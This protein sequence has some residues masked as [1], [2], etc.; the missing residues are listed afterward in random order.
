MAQGLVSPLA[1]TAGRNFYNTTGNT[2]IT[3]N[4]VFTSTV[5]TYNSNALMANLLPALTN[6]AALVSAS[7]MSTA[8][9]NSIRT[10]GNST[11]PALA[12]SVPV[13]ISVTIGNTGVTGQMLANAS[14]YLGSGNFSVFAQAF[15]AALGY[16]TLTNNIINSAVNSNSY[17]GP[18]F[19]NMDDLITGDVTR[20]NLAL[21]VLGQDLDD[22]GE[23]F[24]FANL[25]FFGTPAGL[26]NQ[27]SAR[28]N[29]INGSTPAV[30]AALQ[31][32]G[33]TLQNIADLVNLNVASLFNPQ[34]LTTNQ[35]DA[36][37]KRA[38]PGLCNVIDADL[39]DVLDIL[40]ITTPNIQAMC[41][42]L[43]PAKI[44]PNSYLSLTLPTP[45]GDILIYNEDGSVNSQVEQTLNDGSITPQGCDQLA[46]I[47]P[48]DQAAANRALQV[49]LGQIKN[50]GNQ[51][52]ASLARLLT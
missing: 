9:L 23:L 29:M 5:A 13:G 32:Q 38:Y 14:T 26:L 43:D 28:G 49:A 46:K 33:L 47:I 21:R 37:Q 24:D 39:Q 36:L 8:T 19:E 20:V 42:L 41:D 6:A 11:A 30:T 35:F 52:T 12:D 44:L 50:I 48:A 25:D 27:L 34:G 1:L 16:I 15:G 7:S 45:A 17:L 3:T 2:G 10:L 40:D 18:T 31:D 51:T 4:A 22:L